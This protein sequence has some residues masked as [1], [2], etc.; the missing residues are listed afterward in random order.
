MIVPIAMCRIFPLI[1]AGIPFEPTVRYVYH[2]GP[3]LAR[4]LPGSL[5]PFS[6][7]ITLFHLEKPP[8]DQCLKPTLIGPNCRHISPYFTIYATGS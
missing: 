1:A 7:A 2:E 5:V 8:H 3:P 4:N 6:A